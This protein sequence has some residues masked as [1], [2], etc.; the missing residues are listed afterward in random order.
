MGKQTKHFKGYALSSSVVER[1][2]VVSRVKPGKQYGQS[3]H[4]TRY[5]QLYPIDL[6]VT[7]KL[8]DDK[9]L[10]FNSGQTWAFAIHL[11]PFNAENDITEAL[12]C[13]APKI[14]PRETITV[15]IAGGDSANFPLQ[16]D[17]AD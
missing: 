11:D 3:V 17:I 9:Q 2:S 12:D 5:Y 6:T 7:S 15:D 4:T 14:R 1:R 13:L 10:K 16:V 8:P